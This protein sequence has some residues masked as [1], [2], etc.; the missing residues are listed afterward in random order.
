MI[1]LDRKEV[2]LGGFT[3]PK[4]ITDINIDQSGKIDT[5]TFEDGSQF[6]ERNE[7]TNV[8]GQNIT[9]TIFF[10]DEASASKAYTKIWWMM[11]KLEGD[12]WL[13]NHQSLNEEY[14]QVSESTICSRCH[15]NPCWCDDDKAG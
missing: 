11:T 5:I 8:G 6:P 1:D 13:I 4:K 3:N 7:L 15:K 2:E 12:Q 9:N 10:P 14:A